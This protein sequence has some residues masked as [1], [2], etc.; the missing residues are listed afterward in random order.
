[1]IRE[2][3]DVVAG[4]LLGSAWPVHRYLPDDVAELPCIAVPRPRLTPGDKA[5]ITAAV[6]VL[7]VGRRLNDDD[8]QAELDDVADLVIERF[9]GIT[10]SIATEHP[11]V[12]RL[13]CDDV[14]PNTTVVAGLDYPA[15]ALTITAHMTSC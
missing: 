9:G 15:Y 8:S 4:H 11:L 2:V 5:M 1:M 3:R 13:V 10:R 12:R 14:T 7:V 6:V